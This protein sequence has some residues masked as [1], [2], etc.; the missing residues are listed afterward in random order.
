[1]RIKSI[2]LNFVSDVLPQIIIAIISLFRTKIFLFNLGMDVTGLYQYFGQVMTYLA[3]MDGGLSSAINCRL[4]KPIAEKN[5]EK[6]NQILSA[7]NLIFIFV[8]VLILIVGYGVSYFI[9]SM[10]N[11]NPFSLNFI[12]LAFMIYLIS[13]VFNYLTVAQKSLFESD[14]R[15]YVVNCVF[16]PII[17]VRSLVEIGI[18]LIG[19]D[20]FAIL[21]IQAVFGLLSNVLI[22]ILCK[23]Q[24]SYLN[25][26]NKIKDFSMVKDVSNLMIYKIGSLITYNIDVIIIASKLGLAS[27]AL[28]SAYLL[29]MDNLTNIIGKLVGATMASIGDILARSKDR[30]KQIFDE[31]NSFCFLLIAIISTP[32]LM[33][34]NNF[35]T[36]WYEGKY[37]TTF[38]IS[39]FFVLNF[40]YYISEIPIRVYT[41]AAGL[42]KE[43]RFCPLIEAFVNLVLSLILVQYMGIPGVLCA[44]FISYIIGNYLLKPRII[45]R[46]VFEQNSLTYYIKN[47]GF[48]CLITINFICLN[49]I[50]QF[51]SVQSL[52]AWFLTSFFVFGVN[53]VIVVIEFS[54]TKQLRFLNRFSFVQKYIGFMIK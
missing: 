24:Y 48:A 45:F 11:N 8:A 22:M 7:A 51:L 26:R 32:L 44:T 30:A 18:L 53:L 20:L 27:S 25:L 28:Y 41:N 40:S 31:F 19:G 10:I 29:I 4:Y 33:V 17:I 52:S 34:L 23:R 9:P 47:L 42:F 13:N 36:I 35:L 3:L 21:M 5:Y 50:Y 43:T 46:S 54:L 14:Q 16:Q 2:I 37:E 15:K 39:L 38:L 6:I 49:T 1:M 12:Q